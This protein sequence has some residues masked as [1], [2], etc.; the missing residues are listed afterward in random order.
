MSLRRVKQCYGGDTDTLVLRP[1]VQN[2]VVLDGRFP[3][4]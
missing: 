2:L 4:T 1:L 3:L